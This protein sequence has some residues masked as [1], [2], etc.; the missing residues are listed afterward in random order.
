MVQYTPCILTN[1]LLK[2]VL[3]LCMLLGC[4]SMLLSS[5]V[6]VT[7]STSLQYKPM[8]PIIEV[9]IYVATNKQLSLKQNTIIVVIANIID[10]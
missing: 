8:K 4:Y 6:V 9:E 5:H 3:P 1:D 7:L 2:N 10:Y